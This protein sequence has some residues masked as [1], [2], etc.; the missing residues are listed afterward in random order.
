MVEEAVEA[1]VVVALPGPLHCEKRSGPQDGMEAVVGVMESLLGEEV[2]EAFHCPV[3]DVQEAV[4]GGD[5]VV[6]VQVCEGVQVDLVHLVE[7]RALNEQ[8]LM[9]V[10]EAV[11]AV[12]VAAEI[13]LKVVREEVRAWKCFRYH[14]VWELG[15]EEVV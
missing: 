5:S 8:V 7:P 12:A 1:E 4:E 15:G 11:T 10:R 9:V 3:E 13:L 2:V 14:H 6:V